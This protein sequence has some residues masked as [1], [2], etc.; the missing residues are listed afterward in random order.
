MR[1][2]IRGIEAA[3]AVLLA[4][5][6]VAGGQSGGPVVRTVADQ[7]LPPLDGGRL[8]VTIVEVRY[9]PGASSA[10]HRHPCAVFGY[11]IEGALRWA[12][13][14]EPETTWRAGQTFYEA[15]NGVHRVAANASDREPVRF[16]ATFVCDKDTP[17]TVPVPPRGDSAR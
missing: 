5:C 12:V 14:A 17:L 15:P 2:R 13:N 6:Q 1:R 9:A 16:T 3:L 8:K 4:G 11:I 10:S 7:A